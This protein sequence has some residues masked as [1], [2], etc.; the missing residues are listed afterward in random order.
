[1]RQI[2]DK[3]ETRWYQFKNGIKNIIFWTPKVW[4]NYDFDYY[5][6]IKMF[7]LQLEQQAL[8]SDKGIHL[9]AYID[10]QKI[11]MVLRLMDKVY[12]EYYF[13][14]FHEGT[15]TLKECN[16]KQERAHKLL[17]DLIGYYIRFWWD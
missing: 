5:Y 14:P 8:R 15:M 4:S 12:N 9:N 16:E 2:I 3:L 6:S 10:A 1:M 11:R 13:E 7:R 17:W